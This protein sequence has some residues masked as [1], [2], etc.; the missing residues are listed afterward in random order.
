MIADCEVGLVEI[1]RIG[2]RTI[3]IISRG[4]GNGRIVR[5]GRT[6]IG[7]CNTAAALRV[8]VESFV[9]VPQMEPKPVN[10]I[11]VHNVCTVL[12]EVH[13][14]GHAG[15]AETALILKANAVVSAN[16]PLIEIR[17]LL[18]KILV[19]KPRERRWRWWRSIL[20]LH[21]AGP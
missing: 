14:T 20:R 16:I 15:N 4:T 21:S 9:R 10:K 11:L 2:F 12:A 17:V 19:H 8:D 7:P 1:D 18:A 5:I 6:F 3:P 13:G